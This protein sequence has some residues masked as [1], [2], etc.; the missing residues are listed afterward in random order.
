MSTK[1]KGLN[2]T[3]IAIILLVL[4]VF[5]GWLGYQPG[6]LLNEY[7]RGLG[8]TLLG[9]A[10]C[11][12][13][14]GVPGADDVML[15]YQTTSFHDAQYLRQLLGLKPAPEFEAWLETMGVV[16]Q[17]HLLPIGPRHRL[18]ASDAGNRK[19]EVGE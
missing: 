10:G 16:E 13:F 7:S 11:N 6:T 2:I 14:M 8:L 17:N 1:P 12:Y 9:V 5:F 19:H 3:A 18:L 4:A 15:N